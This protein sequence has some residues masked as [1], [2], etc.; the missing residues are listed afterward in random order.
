MRWRPSRITRLVSACAIPL[1]H[2]HGTH[3]RNEA[4]G[5]RAG[6]PRRPITWPNRYD[7][8]HGHG[9]SIALCRTGA[10]SPRPRNA[11]LPLFLCRPAATVPGGVNVLHLAN[12][13]HLAVMCNPHSDEDSYARTRWHLSAAPVKHLLNAWFT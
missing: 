7:S 4:P 5:G 12:P 3:V 2:S 9:A 13:L 10:Q 8:W 11:T 1:H 6:N